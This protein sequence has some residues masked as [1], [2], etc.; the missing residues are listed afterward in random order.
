MAAFLSSMFDCSILHFLSKGAIPLMRRALAPQGSS[1]GSLRIPYDFLSYC[2]LPLE[3]LQEDTHMV[4]HHGSHTLSRGFQDCQQH[5]AVHSISW[6]TSHRKQTQGLRFPL[7]GNEISRHSQNQILGPGEPPWPVLSDWGLG[8]QWLPG[9]S[10]L[11]QSEDH[12]SSTLIP[13]SQEKAIPE[14]SLW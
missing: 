10:S 8:R 7:P 5:N 1:H 12:I 3:V 13:R 6:A 9:A 2:L 4:W 14:T 11:L